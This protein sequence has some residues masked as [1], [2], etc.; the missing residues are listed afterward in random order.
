MHECSYKCCIANKTRNTGVYFFVGSAQAVDIKTMERQAEAWNSKSCI[1]LLVVGRATTGK[2]ELMQSLL[3]ERT[4]CV[5]TEQHASTTVC[6]FN[7]RE[8]CFKVTI[9]TLPDIAV[10][11]YWSPMRDK[12]GTLDL[13][14]YT[15]R[16]DD[17]QLRPE[18]ASHLHTL[19]KVFG[20]TFWRKGMLALTFANKVTYL[21]GKLQV[22]RGRVFLD[23][24]RKHLKGKIHDVLVPAGISEKVF[25]GIPFVPTGDRSEPLL[26]DEDTEPW[27]NCLT[28]CAIVK[29]NGIDSRASGGV[30][31]A[32][33]HHLELPPDS[34]VINCNLLQ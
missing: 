2:H 6:D 9:W 19:S 24:H 17:F 28:K 21:D 15:L 18:D 33:K 14:M 10:G 16:M 3:G 26:F 7:V 5:S 30:W 4:E 20:D 8:T 11:E 29:M 12:L 25:K 31:R 1:N 32:T 22:R 23:N 34:T 13:V 27:V